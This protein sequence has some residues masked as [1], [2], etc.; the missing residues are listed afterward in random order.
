MAS[1]EKS[2]ANFGTNSIS[3]E[4][5]YPVADLVVS[6]ERAAW[7]MARILGDQFFLPLTAIEV[8]IESGKRTWTRSS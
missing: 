3:E 7:I 1:L 4:W 2:M 6:P 8:L 5:R